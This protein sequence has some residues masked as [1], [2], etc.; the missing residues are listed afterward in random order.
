MK[1]FWALGLSAILLGG[2]ITALYHVVPHSKPAVSPVL[3]SSEKGPLSQPASKRLA[4]GERAL[5]SLRWLGWEVASSEAVIREIVPIQGREAYHIVVLNKSNS[6][7]DMIFKVR[8]EYHSYLDVEDLKTLRFEKVV[9]EGNYRADEE[10][11]FDH[12]TGQAVYHSRLN[13]SH[14]TFSFKPGAVDAIGAVYRYRFQSLQGDSEARFPVTWDEKNYD[15]RI[16]IVNRKV[17]ERS[18]LGSRDTVMVEPY[19]FKASDPNIRSSRV[20]IWVSKSDDRVPI[21][22]RT[23]VPIAGSINAVLK[24]YKS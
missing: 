18:I 3:P 10:I 2:M 12:G 1:R 5:Y 22:M 20:L 19:I 11:D 6:F 17:L 16:P 9:Q 21:K 7:L 15:L 14:K 24:E 13:G 4:V 23:Q 8:D